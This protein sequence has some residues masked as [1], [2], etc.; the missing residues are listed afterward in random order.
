MSELREQMIHDME[1]AGLQ[2]ET[3]RRYLDAIVRLARFHERSPR[4]LGAAEVRAFV[5]ELE[6]S[7]IGPSRLNQHFAGLKFL[8]RKTVGRPE[9]VS[10]LSTPKRPERLPT[11]LSVEQVDRLLAALETPKYRVF[12]TTIYAAGLRISEGCAL[13]TGDIDAARAVIHIRHGKGDKERLVM[14]S[15]R[16]LAILRAYWRQER[17]RAPYL[18]TGQL[19]RPLNPAVARTA[20]RL[21]AA[22]AGLDRKRITPHVLRHSFATHLLEGGTELRVIQALLGHARIETTTRYVRVST[23]LVSQTPSPLEGL[24]APRG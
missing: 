16:L 3:Q 13:E 17:P 2:P 22:S 21:A 8:Y 1:L 23:A 15:P 10:F 12:F 9:V 7:G 6:A 18:F 20:L 11:V 19:G 4:D 5:S 14:L 24:P